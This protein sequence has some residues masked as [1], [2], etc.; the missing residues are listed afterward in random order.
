M[1]IIVIVIIITLTE[2]LLCPMHSDGCLPLIA[3]RARLSWKLGEEQST[4]SYSL[5]ELMLVGAVTDRI[6]TGIKALD[7]L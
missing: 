6:G 5:L 2:G 4:V 7:S 1:I 3:F